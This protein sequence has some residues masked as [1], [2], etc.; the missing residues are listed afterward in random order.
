MKRIFSW[1]A[2][3]SALLVLFWI[4]G[5][6]MESKE[7]SQWPRTQGTVISS[8]LTIDHLPSFLNWKKDPWRM[9]GTR[10][11]YQ[12]YVAFTPYVSDR[13]A[14]HDSN[15]LFVKTALGIMNK[16]RWHREVTVYYNPAAPQQA[17]LEPWN[18]GDLFG[19][20]LT[21]VLLVGICLVICRDTF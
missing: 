9:Y 2:A 7:A 12:Y 11:V 1:I 10:V 3:A 21:A 20:V 8:S 14:I 15:T 13:V 16:Y 18:L 6:L 17:Y 5:L 19:I 4:C